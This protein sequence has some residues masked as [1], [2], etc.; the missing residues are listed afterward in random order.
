M[1]PKKWPFYLTDSRFQGRDESLYAVD[2]ENYHRGKDARKT[3]KKL[4]FSIFLF[5]WE[6]SDHLLARSE[7]GLN[8][9]TTR[10]LSPKERE[11]HTRS[12]LHQVGPHN[13]PCI[14]KSTLFCPRP[15]HNMKHRYQALSS[16]LDSTRNSSKVDESEL[17]YRDTQKNSDRRYTER[18]LEAD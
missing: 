6:S 16:E 2:D 9:D 5:P 3:K 8:F 14:G 18:L 7:G 13:D 10:L 15:I 12:H 11:N 4:V 17:L 1:S